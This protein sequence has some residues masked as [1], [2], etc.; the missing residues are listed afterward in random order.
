MLNNLPPIFDGFS[1]NAGLL[2]LPKRFFPNALAQLDVLRRAANYRPRWYCVP[3]DFNEPIAAYDT[4]Q[5]QIRV[6]PGSYL[7]GLNWTVLPTEDPRV[8]EALISDLYVQITDS[9]SEIPLFNDFVCG[10]ALRP[11]GATQLWPRILG[12]PRLIIEPAL[13]NVEIAN[14][15]SHSRQ[16]QLLLHFAEP[17]EVI[18]KET[19]IPA[20]S[21]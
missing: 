14:T 8:D 10:A 19:G 17:C 2:Y 3:D 12:Q 9:C 5:Y 13:V 20:C 16:C 1:L 7:W 15:R 6:T 11:S 18:T 21:S 4:L